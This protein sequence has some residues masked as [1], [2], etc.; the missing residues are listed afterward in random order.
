MSWATDIRNTLGPPVSENW[1]S[2]IV[3]K[4]AW[5]FGYGRPNETGPRRSSPK[6]CPWYSALHFAPLVL[7]P[8]VPHRPPCNRAEGRLEFLVRAA[9][10]DRAPPAFSQK[11][12]LLLRLLISVPLVV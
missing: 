1:V 9:K 8:K 10:R 6:R 11:A 4:V 3:R 12:P 7:C 2:E 5:S